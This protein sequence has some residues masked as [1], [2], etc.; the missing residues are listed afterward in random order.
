[1]EMPSLT[2]EEIKTAEYFGVDAEYRDAVINNIVDSYDMDDLINFVRN[3][4]VSRFI[5]S[6][7]AFRRACYRYEETWGQGE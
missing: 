6:K 4:L 1:M 7:G 2:K 3:S 5:K